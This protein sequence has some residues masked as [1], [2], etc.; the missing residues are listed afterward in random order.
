MA[1]W[2]LIGHAR[3]VEPLGPKLAEGRDSEIFEHGP[4][5]VLRRARDGRSL[6]GEAEVMR[7]ARSRG[8]PTPEVHDAGEGW[9]VMERLVGPT[10]VE[11]ALRRPWDLG[12]YGAM[13]ASLHSQLHAIVA[14]PD[15]PHAAL[16]GDRLL[17]RDLHPLNII[18]TDQGPMVIDWAN[19]ARGDPAY[20]VADTWVVFAIAEAPGTRLD[21][22]LVGVGRRVL[23]RSFLA[24][25]DVR[26]AVRAIPAAVENRARDRN[27]TEVEQIRMRKLAAWAA[28]RSV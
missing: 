8:F 18:L 22:L 27:M 1:G 25:V 11:A 2:S 19:A 10:M 20:D 7:Y 14:P 4:G 26:A 13:L 28:A 6:A 21:R 9:L 12:R 23:L 5:L 24:R 15:L 3:R 17:H 16:P